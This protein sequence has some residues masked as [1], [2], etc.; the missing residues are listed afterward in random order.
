MGAVLGVRPITVPKEMEKFDEWLRAR[1]I[2]RIIKLP[3]EH[4]NI[5]KKT[6]ESFVVLSKSV[7][8]EG[9]YHASVGRLML[10][11]TQIA[12]TIRHEDIEGFEIYR[13]VR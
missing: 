9:A 4:W 6:Y 1:R 10:S 7:V 11:G 8:E 3:G 13:N 2:K 12:S 5:T